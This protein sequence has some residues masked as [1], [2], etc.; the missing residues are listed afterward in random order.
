MPAITTSVSCKSRRG[1]IPAHLT[2]AVFLRDGRYRYYLPIR[3]ILEPM[4]LKGFTGKTCPGDHF[5][6]YRATNGHGSSL[7]VGNGI[8]QVLGKHTGREMIF[9]FSVEFDFSINQDTRS[10]QFH[11]YYFRA[12]RRLF[13]EKIVKRRN[14]VFLIFRFKF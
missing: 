14:G 10:F 3:F 12:A 13:S 7:W 2:C 6:V 1:I 8:S 11:S 4:F 5:S 9:F